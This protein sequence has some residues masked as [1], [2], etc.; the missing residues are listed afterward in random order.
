MFNPNKKIL[1]LRGEEIPKS[2]PTQKE[3]DKLPKDKLNQPDLNK[4]EKETIGNIILNCLVNYIVRD[5]KEGFYIN[6]IAQSIIA[7]E[8]G[9]QTYPDGTES[10][11]PKSKNIEFKEKI[12]K[13]LVEVLDEMTFRREMEEVEEEKEG[14]KEIKKKEVTKGIYAGWAIAQI[15]NELGYQYD[16]RKNKEEN[17]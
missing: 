10:K 11:V 14:K 8:G 5:R 12:K 1:N 4:L 13:F 2:F 15:L 9:I 3:I 17:K 7:S 16:E 6:L